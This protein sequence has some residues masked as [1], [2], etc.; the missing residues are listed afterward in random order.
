[1]AHTEGVT[2]DPQDVDSAGL[3]PLRIRVRFS[4]AAVERV[5]RAAGIPILHVKG[6]AA[7]PTLR[8]AQRTGTDADVIVRPG[9]A[10]ALVT[11]L[12]TAGWAM[13]ARFETGSV[14]EHAATLWHP[15][16]GYVDVHRAFPGIGVPEDDAFTRLWQDRQELELAATTCA[17]PSIAGQAL[18]LVLHEA[19]EPLG[20]GH[21]ED[22]R[23]AWID[24]D[25]ELR[26]QV[27][28][29]RDELQA[30]IAFAAAE[31]TLEQYRDHPHYRLWRHMRFGGSRL[32]E[33]RARSAA[34]P[35]RRA[36]ARLLVRSLAVNV[37][38][39]AMDLGRPPTRREQLA[40]WWHRITTAVRDLVRLVRRRG[41][42]P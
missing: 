4:H 23:R 32:D 1:M 30:Q 36:A 27:A 11:A 7:H 40:A 19:R 24:A 39:L 6:P 34:A 9:H 17:V 21:D 29:L 38:H 26:A 25:P 42:T 13:R 41:G 37:D 35:T 15:H 20:E 12:L 16:W 2:E 22:V 14:F 10:D 33:W 8:D 3:A 31:G 18:L 28:T 5:A